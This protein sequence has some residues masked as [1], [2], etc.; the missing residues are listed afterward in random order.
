MAIANLLNLFDDVAT[1]MDDVAVLTKKASAKTAALMGDDLAVNSEQ[2]IGLTAT[3]EFPV[4]SKIFLGALINKAILIPIVFALTKFLP[5]G[6][7]IVL[8]LGGLFLCFEGAEKVV[9]KLSSIF[10]KSKHSENKKKDISIDERIKDAVRTDFILSIEILAIAAST[11]T[12]SDTLTT[13]ISLSVVG[14]LVTVIIYGV[15]LLIIKLDDMG[16]ALV[17]KHPSGILNSFGN[18]LITASPKIMKLLGI[19][20]TIAT[21]LVGGDILRHAFHLDF[22]FNQTLQSLIFAVCVGFI[23]VAIFELALKALG[24]SH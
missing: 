18:K 5:I 9:E 17:K 10:G 22:G 15:V 12:N 1:I 7:T 21:F 3:Q 19:I 6:L 20:G 8:I 11:M 23:L 24:K 16:L 4:V 2:M 14:V 13:L